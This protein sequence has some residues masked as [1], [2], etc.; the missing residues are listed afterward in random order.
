MVAPAVVGDAVSLR[1]GI[2]GII[3]TCFVVSIIFGTPSCFWFTG[4]MELTV[5]MPA[6]STADD[7]ARVV[8]SSFL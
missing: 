4:L 8:G 5:A 7:C 2:E 6:V 3:K 1:A